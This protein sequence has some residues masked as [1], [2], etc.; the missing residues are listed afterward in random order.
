MKRRKI[1]MKIV[2]KHNKYSARPNSLV[3]KMKAALY[4]RVS[5]SDQTTLNQE[6][7]LKQYCEKEGWQVYSI[8]KDEGISGAKTSRP[9]LDRLLKDM[10]DR[11]FDVVVVW[12]FDRLGRSTAHLLQVL[13]ELKNKGVRLVA[14]SQ[15]IDTSTPMGKFFFTILSGFAE[16]EREMITERIKLGL[17]RREKEGKPLGR[18]PGARDKVARKRLGYY[19]RWAGKKSTLP[20][21][22]L[23][24]RQK[25]GI[26]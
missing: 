12:K 6:M 15:N 9:E 13:E 16:M 8:Y 26:K 19:E 24:S 3:D 14:T 5:T 1:M 25:Q 7:E 10:R 11:K 4:L 2:P 18:K 22:N 23:E 21:P 20:I 17:K